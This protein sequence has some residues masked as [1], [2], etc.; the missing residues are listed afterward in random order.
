MEKDDYLATAKSFL[1]RSNR[2][3]STTALAPLFAAQ[4]QAAALI[5]IAEALG[6]IAGV[7][8]EWYETEHPPKE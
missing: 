2:T 6:C 4:A 3:E 1:D 5:D 7:L 8:I